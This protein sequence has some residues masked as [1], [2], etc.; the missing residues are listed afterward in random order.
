MDRR[1]LNLVL[2]ISIILSILIIIGF[3]IRNPIP[4]HAE[5]VLIQNGNTGKRLL[6][7]E[8]QK[9]MFMKEFSELKPILSGISI[10]KAFYSGYNYKVSFDGKDITH[11]NERSF[12]S[13]F[14]VYKTKENMIN[15]IKKYE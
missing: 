9:D 13:G 6:L 5:N 3:V 8:E 11:I 4:Q 15:L 12:M 7:S 14:F 2:V 10:S 1:K